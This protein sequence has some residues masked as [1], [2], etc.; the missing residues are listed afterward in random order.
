MELAEFERLSHEVTGSAEELRAG[1]FGEHPY[2]EALVAEVDGV[3]AGYAIFF[4]TFSSF[5]AKPGLWM[6][7]LYV[8]PKFRSMGIGKALLQSLAK[9]TLDR[10]YGRFEWSVLDWNEQAILFYHGIGAKKLRDWR[11]CRLE[12]RAIERA[13]S[14]KGKDC[15]DTRPS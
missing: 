13:A 3:I 7:D 15:E 6:E 4:T 1:F 10:G 9:I 2:A 14:A 5:K 8:A 12:G 11:T